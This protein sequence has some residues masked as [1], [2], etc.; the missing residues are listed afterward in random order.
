M[1]AASL[2]L[3][4]APWYRMP[5]EPI[6]SLPWPQARP[7]PDGFFDR[8]A[9][10]VARELLGKVIRHRCGELWL[11]ARI[12]ETEAYYLAEK[13]SH[14]SLGY[15]E[16]RRALFEGGGHIYMYYARGG[17]SLNFS[18]QGP[19]NAVLIKSAQPWLD[20]QSGDASLAR[21]QANNP[22]A[23]GRPRRP[24]KL[25][26][27]QTLLCKALGLKVP[28]WDAQRFDTQRLFVEEVGER[29]AQIVQTTRL[30]IPA[31]RD[32]HLPYRFVDAAFARFCTRNPLRR[33]QREGRDFQLLGPLDEH[34]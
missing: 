29:P 20:A 2:C 11:S 5:Y 32:E 13:G 15:T 22:D 27:G 23:Q 33:G 14:A 3:A 24:E 25:C 12:I 28:D 9:R 17:D 31:G 6:L 26:A 16:K 1:I 34:L 19:G 30:G 4:V 21:M 10:Q 8:D 18:A 7:L